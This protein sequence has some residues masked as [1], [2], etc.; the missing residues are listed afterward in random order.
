MRNGPAAALPAWPLS[1]SRVLA[2]G[3][4]RERQTASLTKAGTPIAA[5]VDRAR[6]AERA[7]SVRNCYETAFWLLVSCGMPSRTVVP[8]PE[9]DPCEARQTKQHRQVVVGAAVAEGGGASLVAATGCLVHESRTRRRRADRRGAVGGTAGAP[10]W[11]GASSRAAA[12][13]GLA[14]R[15]VGRHLAP[16]MLA[17]WVSAGA[18]GR[19][20]ATADLPATSPDRVAQV[21][22]DY[23]LSLRRSVNGRLL[24]E[25]PRGGTATVL[26]LGL[27]RGGAVGIRVNG[28]AP[29]SVELQ[30]RDLAEPILPPTVLV[31]PLSSEPAVPLN[32]PDIR[33]SSASWFHSSNA[34]PRAPATVAASITPSPSPLV[35]DAPQ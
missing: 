10:G 14:G 2:R 19:G 9:P 30:T 26:V 32:F 24:F 20:Q 11:Q 8:Y 35:V 12:G 13:R 3:M 31:K 4:L 18:F 28:A 22:A 21:N 6:T 34:S 29:L 23:A 25:S 33:P 17:L 15:G 16:V 1:W 7:C 27:Q 5:T